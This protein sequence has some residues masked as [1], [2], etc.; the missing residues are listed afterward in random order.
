MPFLDQSLCAILASNLEPATREATIKEASRVVEGGGLLIM[1]G[2]YWSDV[3]V[4][5]KS[6]FEV[7]AYTW[8]QLRLREKKLL[9]KFQSEG[10]NNLHEIHAALVKFI[11]P[12][13]DVVARRMPTG[14]EPPAGHIY[15]TNEF[16]PN[17]M[18]FRKK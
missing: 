14:N 16:A 9:E 11:G 4:A 10:V 2:T 12:V 17:Y 7:V 15:D 1:Q 3:V 18:V 13:F 8:N 6:G 5:E